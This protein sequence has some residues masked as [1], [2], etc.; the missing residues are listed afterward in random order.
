MQAIID[1]V[2]KQI[3]GIEYALEMNAGVITGTP[4]IIELSTSLY[5]VADGEGY[6]A[7]SVVGCV[8]CYS[9]DRIDAAVAH[10]LKEHGEVFPKARKVVRVEALRSELASHRELLA[11]LQASVDAMAA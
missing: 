11:R 10:I 1:T 6:R 7:G 3:A 5:L 8:A 9:A 4:W 2:K